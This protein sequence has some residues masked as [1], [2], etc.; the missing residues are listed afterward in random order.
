MTAVRTAADLDDS[1]RDL[2]IEGRAAWRAHDYQVARS[3]FA[4]ALRLTADSDD[5]FGQMTA[6]HFLGNL[7]FNERKNDESREHHN[8]ALRLA[9]LDGDFQ[10]IATSLGSL[11]HIE[12]AEGNGGGARALYDDAVAA[13][14]MASMSDAASRL[15]ASAD[16]LVSGRVTLDDVVHRVDRPSPT[17]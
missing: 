13:Y 8:S 14:E 12:L 17:E 6:H 15:R 1:I 3:L 4:E 11:A 16:D 5:R 9:R 7:A 2:V 10:G